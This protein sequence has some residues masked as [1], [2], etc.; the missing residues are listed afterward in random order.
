MKQAA[1]RV[2]VLLPVQPVCVGCPMRLQL[3][4]V[5]V[6]REHSC[7]Q[8][9]QVIMHEEGCDSCSMSQQTTTVGR[10]Y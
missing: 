5:H 3:F 6:S 10:Q 7:K 2:L 1:S 4:H 9:E 8:A